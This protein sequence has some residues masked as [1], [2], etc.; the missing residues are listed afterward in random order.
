MKIQKIMR[1][2]SAFILYLN[3]VCMFVR[4]LAHPF[5]RS[6]LV[7]FFNFNYRSSTSNTNCS[8]APNYNC[9]WPIERTF[10][11]ARVWCWCSWTINAHWFTIR[12]YIY[13]CR[14]DFFF[15]VVRM[16]YGSLN[17]YK[18]AHDEKQNKRE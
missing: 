18:R 10:T 4:W 16:R 2:I 13:C 15:V 3:H 17:E 9:V 14:S 11:G 8:F 7:F 5:V 12:G 6:F 1:N